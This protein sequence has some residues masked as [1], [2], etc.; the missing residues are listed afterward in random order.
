M[1]AVFLALVLALSGGTAAAASDTLPGDFLYPY[2]LHVNEN[3]RSFFALSEEARADLAVDLASRRLNEAERLALRQELSAEHH[4][5]LEARFQDRIEHM[6]AIITDLEAEGKTEA[7]AELSAKLEAMLKA[8]EEILSK[9]EAKAQAEGEVNA[10]AKINSGLGPLLK[11]IRMRHGAAMEQR[12]EL[13]AKL[14]GSDADDRAEVMS[15]IHIRQA[16]QK[17]NLAQNTLVR[18]EG[19]ISAD[20]KARAEGY[21]N[22]ANELLVQAKTKS[23]AQEFSEAIRLALEAQA[24]ALNAELLLKAYLRL[25]ANLKTELEVESETETDTE[26]SNVEIESGLHLETDA[27]FELRLQ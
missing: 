4:A 14:E 22:T 26:D 21:I 25:D 15:E 18:A 10:E 5:M 17:L 27:D 13:E 19:K 7:A 20:S 23:E 9:L 6:Q 2:K 12:A 3:V 16:E 8:H 11:N 24:Q 1:P